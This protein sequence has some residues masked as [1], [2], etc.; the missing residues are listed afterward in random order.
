MATL[1]STLVARVRTHLIDSASERFG[2][3]EIR[4]ALLAEARALFASE[5]VPSDMIGSMLTEGDAVEVAA[6]GSFSAPDAYLRMC[7]GY[8]GP[9]RVTRVLSRYGLGK[10]TNH[11]H[12][13]TIGDPCIFV[14]AGKTYL[15]PPGSFEGQ[16][17]SILYVKREIDIE[18]IPAAFEDCISL[19]AASR[20]AADYQE[21]KLSAIL[22]N[23]SRV[24]LDRVIG[25]KK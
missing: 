12:I 19:G 21:E 16:S 17:I 24:H 15:L 3:P 18:S 7:V 20:L 11:N 25:V 23:R 10:Q 6:D 22:S 4:E 8:V 1:E 5:D 9:T 2:E 13:A 14:E